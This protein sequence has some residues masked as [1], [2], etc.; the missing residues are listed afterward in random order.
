MTE[1]IAASDVLV[2]DNGLIYEG[3]KVADA[4]RS[5]ELMSV[6]NFAD[7][8]KDGV[9]SRGE[10][11]RYNAPIFLQCGHGSRILS[12]CQGGDVRTCPDITQV[13]AGLKIE[14]T[15][16]AGRNL[17]PLI[18]LNQDGKIT[19][20]EMEK[21]EN[22]MKKLDERNASEITKNET[23]NILG[24]I[25]AAPFVLT[26][27]VGGLFCAIGA[28]GGEFLT[29]LAGIGICMGIVLVGLLGYAAIKYFTYA[30][31]LEKRNAEFLE[32]TTSHPYL[33]K[34]LEDRPYEM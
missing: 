23:T 11:E 29:G 32:N 9:I 10:L 22:V 6:F 3:M 12:A 18:D 4:N 20:T 16:A 19:K 26:G 33:K 2:S 28:G 1:V 14:E 13:Y 27:A 24:G 5:T 31:G 8:D 21:L 17:F 25:F 7:K 30:K 15:T 34:Y